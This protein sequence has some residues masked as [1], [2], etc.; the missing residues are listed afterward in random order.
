MYKNVIANTLQQ[1]YSKDYFMKSYVLR[2][3]NQLVYNI[4]WK[5]LESHIDNQE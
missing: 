2:L 4:T 5:P 1:F 3:A